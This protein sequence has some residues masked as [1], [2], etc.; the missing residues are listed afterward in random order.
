MTAGKGKYAWM[1]KIGAA[2][3]VF[4]SCD[5]YDLEYKLSPGDGARV[6]KDLFHKAAGRHHAGPG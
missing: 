6:A 2:D 1:V 5:G 3:A 4:V